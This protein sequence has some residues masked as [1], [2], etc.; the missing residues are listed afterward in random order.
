MTREIFYSEELPVPVG[1]FP[2]GAAYGKLVY[3]SGCVGQIP[4]TGELAGDSIQEQ[5][6]QALK[7]IF[8]AVKAGGATPETIIKVNCYLLS[9]NDFAPFNEVYKEFFSG[10]E[11]PART[12]IAVAELPLKARVEIEAV[13]F[14]P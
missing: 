10:N 3:L 12:C 4:E 2:A 9:M 13:A 7:N 5:A 1:P 6:R 11:F 8:S 14:R